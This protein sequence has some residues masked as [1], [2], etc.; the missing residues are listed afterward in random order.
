MDRK[1]IRECITVIAHEGSAASVLVVSTDEDRQSFNSEVFRFSDI[2]VPPTQIFQ[3]DD[4]I[5]S[6]WASSVGTYFLAGVLGDCF[7]NLSGSFARQQATTNRLFRIWGLHDHAVYAVG[8]DGTCVRFDGAR[9]L[10]MSEGLSGHLYAISGRQE[11][12]LVC[13]GDGGFVARYDGARWQPIELPT[14][15]AFRAVHVINREDLYLCG[16]DGACYLLRGGELTS[17]D[18]G[19]HDLYAIEDFQG[20]TYFAS[21]ASGVF[22]IKGDHLVLV[23]DKARG[24]SLSATDRFLWSCGLEQTARFDGENWRKVD[25]N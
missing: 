22:K 23:K 11:D 24:Y 21:A 15:A 14:N 4:W 1:F 17:I 18:A 16:L 20:E 13:A 7:T 3:V 5:S 19:G 6:M 10:P 8:A 25:F 9:W 2:E 12:N